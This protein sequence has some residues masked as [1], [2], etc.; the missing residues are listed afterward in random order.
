MK[1]ISLRF[2]LASVVYLVP[3]AVAENAEKQINVLFNNI[4]VKINGERVGSDNFLYQGTT[5]LP[6]C[7][8][9]ER[10]GITVLWD[11]HTT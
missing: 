1:N 4:G 11:D 7:E 9:N 10:L 5:Y 3:S 2:L 8:I 6:L